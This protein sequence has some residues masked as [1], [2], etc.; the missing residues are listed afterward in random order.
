MLSNF[1]V[2]V[3]QGPASHVLVKEI[4]VDQFNLSLSVRNNDP[5]VDGLVDLML[6]PVGNPLFGFSGVNVPAGATVPLDASGV[7]SSLWPV[8]TYQ[9]EVI[10]FGGVPPSPPA[11]L[12]RHQFTMTATTGG[13]GGPNSVTITVAPPTNMAIGEFATV[14]AQ[15][16]PLTFNSSIEW[17]WDPGA[18]GLNLTQAPFSGTTGP[19]SIFTF[20]GP[21]GILGAVRARVP[22]GLGGFLE[23]V[24]VVQ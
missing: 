6:G 7:T 1:Q 19:I 12:F 13:G 20:P 9:A 17:W 23:D 18:D 8:G 21:N 14:A 16:D 11:Q 10:V 4:G 3:L 15:A 24:A 5:A 2:N 22:D